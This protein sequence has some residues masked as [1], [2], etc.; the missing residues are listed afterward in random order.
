M[1]LYEVVDD[2]RDLVDP[3]DEGLVESVVLDVETV[4]RDA[5]LSRSDNFEIAR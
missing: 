5:R 1:L 4:V 3:A 2:R